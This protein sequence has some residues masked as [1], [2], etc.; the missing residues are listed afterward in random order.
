MKNINTVKP[1]QRI[2]GFAVIAAIGFAALSLT[3][4]SFLD[5]NNQTPTAED[6][7]ISGTGT[8]THDGSAKIVT[9]TA[10]PDKSTGAVTVKYNNSTTAPSAVGTYTVTFDVA[11]ATGWNAA[12]GLSAGTLTINGLVEMVYVP[13]GS[14]QM[15]DVKNEGYDNEKPVHPVTLTGFYMGK[16]EV[17]QAQYQAVM[18]TNPSYFSSNPASGEVQGNRPVEKVSWY[19]AIEFCNALSIQEGLIPYYSIDKVNKDPNNDGDDTLKWTVTVNSAANGYRLPT[20]AQ[21]EYAAK[22]GNGTLGNYT[23]SGSNTVDDVAWYSRNSDNKTHEV[24]KKAANGLGIYDMSGNVCEWCWDWYDRYTSSTQTDPVGAATSDGRVR[25]GRSWDYDASH[26]RSAYRYASYPDYRDVNIGFRLIRPANAVSSVTVTFDSNGGSSVPSQ[27]VNSGTTAT[28][29]TNPTRSGYTF[30]NWYSNSGLTTVYNFSTPVTWNITLYAKWN[31]V[32]NPTEMVLYTGGY[33]HDYNST[34]GDRKA[35]YWKGTE[36]IILPVPSNATFSEVSA[37]TVADGIVYTAGNYNVGVYLQ[38]GGGDWVET[39]CYWKGTERINLPVPSGTNF[40]RVSAIT[41]VGGTVYTV[42]YYTTLK[43]AGY[44]RWNGCYWRGT[45]RIDLTSPA[46]ANTFV[47]PSA[48]AVAGGTV[49]TAG[50]YIDGDGN[51]KKEL[52]WRGTEWTDLP[53]PSGS[54]EIDITAI[55]VEGGTVYTTGSYYNISIAGVDGNSSWMRACYWRGAERIDLP[56]PSVAWTSTASALAVS[57]GTVHTAGWYYNDNIGTNPCYWRGTERTEIGPS[58]PITG[59]APEVNAISVVGETIYIA[60]FDGGLM[61]GYNAWYL[62]NGHRYDIGEVNGVITCSFI[63]ERSSATVSSFTV[64][65]D[66]NGGSSV[67][68]QTINSGATATR[69]TNPTRSGYTF[70]DWYSNSGLTT[71]YNFS[72]PITGNITLYAK[73][74]PIAHN[75]TVIEMVYVPGGSFQMG[76]ELGT[77]GF[78]DVTPVHTVMMSGFYIGKYLLTQAQYQAVMGSNPSR[79]FGVGNNY[80]VYNVNWYDAIEFCNALSR[81]EGLSPYYSIDKENKDPNNTN[82]WEK[83]K[84][85][86]T[87]NITAN[88]YRLPTEAQWEYAAKGGNGSPGNYTYSGSNTAEDVAWSEGLNSNRMIHE[89]GKKAPNGL[90]IYDMSGNMA[91]WCWDW[92]GS[93]SNGAQTDPQGAATSNYRIVRGGFWYG[94]TIDG[95]TIDSRTVVYRINSTADS[96]SCNLGF[97]LVRPSDSVSSITVFTSIAEF[98]AWLSSQPANTAATAYNVALNVSDL[99]GGPTH[100]PGSI[101]YVL[102]NNPTKYVNLDLSGSTITSI[103]YKAFRWCHNLVSI[104]IPNSVTSIGDYT[105]DDCTNLTGVTIPNSV[106]GIGD[107]AF[108]GCTGLISITI[109]NSVTSIGYGVFLSCDSLTEIIVD[110]GNN[111]YTAED[112]VL[113]NKNK[114]LLHTYPAGK[115]GTTFTISNSVTSIGT[116]AFWGCKS[117]TSVTIPNSVSSIEYGAFW[118]CTSLASVTFQSANIDIFNQYDTLPGNLRAKYLAGGIGTYT[119]TNPGDNAVWTKQP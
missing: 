114:T 40:S 119:T 65:F 21:W 43:P 44:Q 70:V 90:G 78:G 23:Y 99:G 76:K 1:I 117:L 83:L 37:I 7:D 106:T 82:S 86:V 89:V 57:G 45:E 48:I 25:R 102:Y 66:S 6:Y 47:Y 10:K 67:P 61:D 87:R 34:S 113:Y 14:F 77:A 84:W 75:S 58:F 2:A 97:R 71:V 22:G 31:P 53:V 109:P 62:K 52:Y 29:P 107:Y 103:G 33:Y 54:T 118:S 51:Y 5:L 46:G 73:W 112:G 68:S 88:G 95:Y 24:G 72:T 16:Y 79:D 91:E 8:F 27:T 101:G 94:D 92:E 35:S 93:Y 18:G 42:G 116:Y 36:R 110:T 115:T 111:A 49:Y 85:T 13:G 55:T 60:G 32:A 4:C 38:D 30:D 12:R 41:V 98:A 9:V 15:G 104:T 3:G 59:G 96:G 64:T 74:N 50:S 56:I 19:D 108:A 17:T 81:K 80:P 20:E 11:V 105:F 26:V 63:L 100:S 39:A 28:R 69:P